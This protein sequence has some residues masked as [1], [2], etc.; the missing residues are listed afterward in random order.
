VS[1]T[2]KNQSKRIQWER[3]ITRIII[4][5]GNANDHRLRTLTVNQKGGDEK[6]TLEEE[7]GKRGR[8]DTT[9]RLLGERGLCRSLR[10][11]VHEKV[12]KKSKKGR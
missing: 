9:D 10:T 8:G 12:K 4:W 1:E 6:K 3:F 7:I 5:G 2:R 11:V